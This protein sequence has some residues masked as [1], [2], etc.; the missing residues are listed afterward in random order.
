MCVCVYL[1]YSSGSWLLMMD[2]QAYNFFNRSIQT[3]IKLFFCREVL[4]CHLLSLKTKVYLTLRWSKQMF[5]YFR[6]FE[7]VCIPIWYSSDTGV[8]QTNQTCDLVY[9]Q[10]HRQ[11][12]CSC[13]NDMVLPIWF[14]HHK[15]IFVFSLICCVDKLNH[16]NL[17]LVCFGQ[18]L[19]LWRQW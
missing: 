2:I 16:F 7:K 12:S 1:C 3:F 11:N 5:E 8:L 9:I 4:S 14:H 19:R 6:L 18:V 17:I 10:M 13:L 15:S